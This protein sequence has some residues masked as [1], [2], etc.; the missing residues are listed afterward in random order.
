MSKCIINVTQPEEHL[1]VRFNQSVFIRCHVSMSC[2]KTTHDVLWYVFRTDSYNQLDIKDSPMKYRLQGTDL[3]INQLS[4]GDDGV[5][6][7]AALYKDSTNSG[8]QDIGTGTKLTVKGK[9]SCC[10]TDTVLIFESL[11]NLS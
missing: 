7:C 1:H 8:A 3:H 10:V 4:D 2:S 6:H 11:L 5:Y 9:T